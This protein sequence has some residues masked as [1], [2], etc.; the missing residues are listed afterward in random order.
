[1]D[2]RRRELATLRAVGFGGRPVIAATLLEAMLVAL[3]GAV[4]GAALA[5]NFF[6]DRVAS[7]FGFQFHL[8]VTPSPALL[9]IGWALGIGL[10]AGVLPALRATRV[11]VSDALRA[12]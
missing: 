9:G 5:W 2:G 4:L 8:A 12:T 11:S 6:D 1:M 10:I 7:P 3:A